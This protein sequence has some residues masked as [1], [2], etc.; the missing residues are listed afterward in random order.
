MPNR[1]T[2]YYYDW[3]DRQVATKNAVAS[4]EYTTDNTH[5]ITYTDLDNLGEAMASYTY[6]GDTV[7]VSFTGSVPDK[8]SS[9]LLRAKTSMLYDE[10]GRVFRTTK[11]SVDPSSGSFSTASTDTIVSNVWY[12]HRGEVVASHTSGG[13]T[14]KMTYDGPGRVVVSYV[15]DGGAVNN[16]TSADTILMGWSNATSNTADVVIEQTEYAYDGDGNVIMQ[17]DRQRFD[18]DT[19]SALGALIN[20]S[21]TTGHAARVYVVSNYYDAADR[22]IMT[23]NVGTNGGT[24]YTRARQCHRQHPRGF[25]ADHGLHLQ[26]GGR[27]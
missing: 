14:N 4:T 13:A 17:V 9:S 5:F 20:I 26:C 8:P 16:T 18:N 24:V 11:Y 27:T 10:Q 2:Q 1:V 3:R 25:G 7:T 12:D 15:T 23:V 19:S 6:D 21:D 22:L